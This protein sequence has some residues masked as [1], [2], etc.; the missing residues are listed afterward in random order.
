MRAAWLLPLQAVPASLAGPVQ[1]PALA[2]LESS[3]ALATALAGPELPSGR[4]AG[5]QRLGGD[6]DDGSY[7]ADPKAGGLLCGVASL[8]RRSGS[9][10]FS[11]RL[12][13]RQGSRCVALRLPLLDP[14]PA[15]PM[16]RPVQRLRVDPYA[17]F[18]RPRG[19]AF[20]LPG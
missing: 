13:S 2:S 10:K 7:R 5:A 9:R 6:D 16:C 20:P 12:P 3:C 4:T 11:F 1:P 15:V 19:P 17:F 8:A 18:A 14:Y